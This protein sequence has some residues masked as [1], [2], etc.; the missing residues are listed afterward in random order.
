MA[1]KNVELAQAEWAS[2]NVLF[3]KKDRTLRFCVDYQRLNA[4]KAWDWYN[5]RRMDDYNDYLGDAKI[6]SA[7]DAN[8][9]IW[10]IEVH[11]INRENTAFT[12]RNASN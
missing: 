3:Q 1:M 2:P 12:L 11:N 7:R 6:F 10:H 8:S 9:D 4:A 5:L